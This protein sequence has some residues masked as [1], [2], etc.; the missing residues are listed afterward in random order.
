MK[1]ALPQAGLKLALGAIALTPRCKD[2]VPVFGPAIQPHGI[3]ILMQWRP[4]VEVADMT[5]VLRA[6]R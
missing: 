5:V 3:C 1:V 6:R 2:L 4:R